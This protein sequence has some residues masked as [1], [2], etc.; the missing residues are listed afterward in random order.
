MYTRRDFIKTSLIVA[1]GMTVGSSGRVFALAGGGEEAQFPKTIEALQQRYADEI[2][3]YLKF[4]V[5]VERAEEEGYPNIAHLFRSLAASEAIHARNF[6]RILNDLGAQVELQEIPEFEGS[7]TKDNIRDATAVEADEIDREYP[8]ILKTIAPENHGEAVLFVTY[9]WESEK[10]HR[11]LI[12]KIQRAVKRWFGFLVKRIE[13]KPTHYYV[14]NICGS[15][16]TK[17]P[18]DQ[19]PICGQP[20]S[21][22]EEVPGFPGN[23]MQ[24]E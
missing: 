4:N 24:E 12:L 15:S 1:T 13:A 2:I 21:E 8:S 7:S 5:Y 14:C 19:C 3:A 17:L 9:A 10:Q 11:A 6:K 16:V 22:Y 23:Q 18:D 20:V